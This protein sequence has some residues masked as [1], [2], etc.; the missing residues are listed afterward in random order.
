MLDLLVAG[1]AITF[2]PQHPQPPSLRRDPTKLAI[3]AE[4]PARNKREQ[5]PLSD[6]GV[7]A[8]LKWLAENK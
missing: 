6:A 3:I 4:V 2:P 1:A 7:N 5:F 8:A